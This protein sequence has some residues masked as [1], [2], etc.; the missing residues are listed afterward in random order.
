[1]CSLMSPTVVTSPVALPCP[2][3]WN[4]LVDNGGFF[5]SPLCYRHV[6]PDVKRQLRLMRTAPDG[7]KMAKLHSRPSPQYR[8][9]HYDPRLV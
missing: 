8:Y 6:G 5:Y 4:S 2:P 3:A 1:M 7:V 9:E